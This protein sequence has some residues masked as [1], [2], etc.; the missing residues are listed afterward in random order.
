MQNFL[1]VEKSV[2]GNAWRARPMQ[3]RVAR[4]ISQQNDLPELLGRVL[5]ARGV[6][7]DSVASVMSPSLREMMPD[8]H[9]LQDMEK[10]AKRVAEAIVTDEQIAIIGDYDVDGTTSS[11]LLLQFLKSL[12]RTADIHIPNRLTEGYGP[13]KEAISNLRDR[14]AQLLITVDCGIRAHDPLEHANDR[15]QVRIS[16]RFSPLPQRA[17]NWL[18]SGSLDVFIHTVLGRV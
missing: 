8:P 12:D 16:F 9:T 1:G 6:E 14:G 13:G 18:P 7:L 11:T 10:A 4:A 15:S 2:T 3:D 5:A 17:T